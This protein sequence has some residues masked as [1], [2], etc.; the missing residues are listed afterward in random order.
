[1]SSNLLNSLAPKV[2][3]PGIP[4]AQV[5]TVLSKLLSFIILVEQVGE[6]LKGDQKLQ[7]VLA[8]MSNYLED[9]VDASHVKGVLAEIKWVAAF[10]VKAYNFL[11]LWPTPAAP[12]TTIIQ[13]Q[14]PTSQPTPAPK[15]AG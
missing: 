9:I 11:K 14:Q 5:L 2:T 3:L 15:P 8:M 12:Q 7:T 6:E 1:M 10:I 4:V 13:A